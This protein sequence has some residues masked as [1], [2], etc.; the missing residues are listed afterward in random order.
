[1]LIDTTSPEALFR[2]LFLPLYPPEVQQDLATARATD[3]N[4][5]RNPALFAQLTDT[6]AVLARL[7]P[8]ALGIEL[9]GSDASIHRL[10]ESLTKDRR[11]QLLAADGPDGV[12]VLAHLVIHGVAYVGEAVVQHHGGQWQLRRPLWESLVKLKSRAGEGDLAIFSWWLRAL[13]DGEIG[14]GTLAER[15]RRH[16]ELPTTRPEEWP[17]IALPDRKLPRLK[18]PRYDTLHRYLRAQ[19]PEMR[20]LGQDFPS[21]ERFA[22]FA[23]EWLD[24]ILLGGGRMLLMH[25]PTDRGIHLFWL[26]AA[27]FVKSLYFPADA[28][29]E[30]KVQVEGDIVR[31]LAPVLNKTVIQEVLWWGP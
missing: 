4:P 12:P 25:G 11:D 30:H 22:E 1:M 10:A 28:F 9:D 17:V 19:L 26:D 27:G 18:R 15:Y 3:A 23:F 8:G 31:V 14:R 16:V 7:A 2:T 24:F 21:P 5:A 6:A 20:D 13:S 29:P